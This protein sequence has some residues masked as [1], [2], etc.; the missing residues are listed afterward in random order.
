MSGENKGT[1]KQAFKG[2]DLW[3][4]FVGVSQYHD[5]ELGELRYCEEDA[6][7]LAS[8]FANPDVGGYGSSNI[9]VLMDSS[10][11]PSLRPTRNNVISA[12]HQLALSAGKEDSIIFGFF[13][14]GIDVDGVS[15]LFACD[16][17]HSTPLETA[18]ELSWIR[19]TLQGSQAKTKLL[20]IDACHSGLL[21]GRLGSRGMSEAFAESL[22]EL[23]QHE[24]WAVLSACKQSQVSHECDD[25][26]HGIFTYYL[27]EGLLGDAD[28]D[29]DGLITLFEIS[30]YA[31]RHTK[32]W[33][34]ERGYEQTPELHCNVTGN[35]ILLNRQKVTLT[36]K[37]PII[38]VMGTKGGTGKSTVISGMAELVASTG[39]N[40][41]IIDAD[42]E[43]A[44]ISKYLSPRALSR[45]NVWTVMDAAYA[46]QNAGTR[47]GDM[48]VWKVTPK[49]LQESQFGDIYLIPGRLQSDYRDPYIAMAN[50]PPNKRN[51][52]AIDILREMVDRA[53]KSD[54]DF[55]LIDSGAENNP[56][57][58][59]GFA[60][61]TYG[62]IVSSPSR[63]FQGEKR[64]LDSMHRERYPDENLSAMTL[65]VNQAT[66]ETPDLWEDE[67]IHI[68]REDPIMRRQAAIGNFDFKGVGLCI[69]F[70][71]LL[72]IL[73]CCL[74]EDKQ[75]FLPDE[76]EVWVKPFLKR[77]KRFPEEILKKKQ[78]KFLKLITAGVVSVALFIAAISTWKF[79][80]S[81]RA[82]KD[83]VISREI[84]IPPEKSYEISQ[85]KIPN[86]F[87]NRV[88][89]EGN[90]LYFKGPISE[91]EREQLKTTSEFEPFRDA[92]IEGV[93]IVNDK[94]K[95]IARESDTT[96]KMAILGLL[97]AIVI[98]AT[99]S[100]LHYYH[101]KRKNFVIRLINVLETGEKEESTKLINQIITSDKPLLRWLKEKFEDEFPDDVLGR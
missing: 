2:G 57:V 71:D 28:Y 37:I 75:E 87:D 99:R 47:K 67:S 94:V 27:I 17:D 60:L 42:I 93:L 18:I 78:Y 50:I 84:I 29:R 16:S 3:A 53:I 31:D 59:A 61:C 65:I 43:T 86:G 30:D 45:P 56:L 97:A 62:F 85:I 80:E 51:K 41:L 13:G 63:E 38:S 48:S 69:F 81:N 58:S 20:I 98:L 100:Y 6:R 8:L 83:V 89:L 1:K 36:V 49:Y 52:A 7:E 64:R 72:R 40:V 46:E 34:F 5:P 19:N 11:E 66:P 26:K 44:G 88:W 76:W 39:K 90:K 70:L 79:I 74:E 23:G 82:A 95:E 21:R 32:K 4:V 54:A 96:R 12:V 101:T 33:A 10:D 91:V 14:H 73:K 68:I 55:I 22:K 9:R 35:I 24:G 15:Y 25:K 77:M 92:V